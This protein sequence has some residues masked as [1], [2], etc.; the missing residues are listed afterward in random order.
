MNYTKKDKSSLL[1]RETV[2]SLRNKPVKS[3]FMERLILSDRATDLYG[4]LSQPIKLG[5]CHQYVL[6]NVSCPVKPYD[7]LLGRFEEHVPTEEEEEI[8]N[9]IH[10]K[11]DEIHMYMV[12]MGH[13]TF[14]WETIVK[15]GLPGLIE[16]AERRIQKQ[17][18]NGGE[19]KRV[20]FLRGM[21]LVYQ[22]YLRFIERYADAA[23]EAGLCDAAEVCRNLVKGAPATFREA[24]Q[25]VLFIANIFSVY[26]ARNNATLC[27]GRV[28]EYLLPFY[29][30]DIE[31]G[32]LT[33]EDA[34]YIID[35][36]NCKIALLTG[37]GEHQMSYKSEFATGWFRNPMYDSPTYVIIGGYTISGEYRENP[38]TK[39]F[40]E[41][42]YPRLENPLYVFRRT[43][44]TTEDLW[45]IVCD[46]LRQ[47]STLLVYNDETVIPAMLRSG[48]KA[49]DANNY[50]IHGCN[51]PD[52]HGASFYYGASGGPIPGYIMNALFDDNGRFIKEFG[53]IDEMYELIGQCW[54]NYLKSEFAELRE[55]MRGRKE[56]PPDILR[57]FE[58]FSRGSRECATS[59][60]YCAEYLM[61][62]VTIRN[63][64]TAAD[65]MAAMEEM[66]FGDDP[67]SFDRLADALWENFEGFEDILKRCRSAPKYGQDDDRADRHAVR[68]M[69]L[70]TDIV[71]EESF[72]SETGVQDIC[73]LCVTTTDMDH[74]YQG[75]RMDATPDGRRAHADLSENL[76]PS[77]NVSE[78]ATALLNS[79]SKLPLDRFSAGAFNVRMPKNFVSGDAGLENLKILLGTY[80]ED[81]G[82]QVQISVA[83]TKE[84]RDAQKNPD[85]YRDLMVR[86]T[87]YS[88][89]FVDMIDHAQEEIIKRDEMS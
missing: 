46:K 16:D 88:A 8:I 39:L 71:Y 85:N 34:G 70:F 4:G 73:A 56:T 19:A 66:L 35:D 40:L 64:G 72:D 21:S 11:H 74:I 76:S 53:A 6:E 69:N 83:D 32:I 24:I 89:L 26:S 87:G 14:D 28:D 78:S 29:Q 43:K 54:R 62:Y 61:R 20:I 33:R 3:T 37:R 5:F 1:L 55:F 81:G 84:L 7:I 45:T 75:G 60:M 41:R 25:L 82:M 31:S 63:I 57:T 15:L 44:N 23:E 17:L 49:A 18:A 86:I 13:C 10:A 38:L 12:D 58:C 59:M 22:A 30:R 67:V 79:V 27:C 47:N 80:F 2:E 51:W 52:I 9:E 36:F 77:R 65:M 68:L 50:T 48:V 42:L